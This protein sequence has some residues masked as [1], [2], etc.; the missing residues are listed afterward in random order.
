MFGDRER[1]RQSDW[2]GGSRVGLLDF[3]QELPMRGRRDGKGDFDM[4]GNDGFDFGVRAATGAVCEGDAKL[5][6]GVEIGAAGK[7][8][9][10]LQA[11]VGG[12]EKL[13]ASIAAARRPPGPW[14]RPRGEAAV[15]GAAGS[16]HAAI[17]AARRLCGVAPIGA[18]EAR[19]EKNTGQ[20]TD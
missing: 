8:T 18:R 4:L 11:D 20:K 13:G 16:F 17:L 10:H 14:R 3:P 9:E 15:G 19:R 5:G 7:F 1:R 6:E 12:F 2:L